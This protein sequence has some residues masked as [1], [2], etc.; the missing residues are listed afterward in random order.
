MSLRILGGAEA[1]WGCRHKQI[2]SAYKIGIQILADNPR[3]M[4]NAGRH[5]CAQL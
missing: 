5:A 3:K 4:T 2:C 1:A